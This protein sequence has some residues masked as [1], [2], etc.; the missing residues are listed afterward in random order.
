MNDFC[1]WIFLL[2]TKINFND[3]N[4]CSPQNNYLHSLIL[5]WGRAN[6]F[7]KIVER[8][9]Y[10]E[11]R[12]SVAYYSQTLTVNT[13]PFRGCIYSCAS[14]THC[15]RLCT[16]PGR[17]EHRQAQS[18]SRTASHRSFCKS[19]DPFPPAPPCPDHGAHIARPL[20]GT[21]YGSHDNALRRLPRCNPSPP[22]TCTSHYSR[23]GCVAPPFPSVWPE[24]K[25]RRL[26][27]PID[28]CCYSTSLSLTVCLVTW[29]FQRY[30]HV[31]IWLCMH[32]RHLVGFCNPTGNEP[33]C[34]FIQ[35]Q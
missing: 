19:L 31:F 1:V 13:Y 24:V 6:T 17:T 7:S 26:P 35:P 23:T 22:S 14:R 29:L 5:R 32:W 28:F 15:W 9:G 8:V 16:P 11:I 12:R 4:C 27:M 10:W 21:C 25:A 20:A 3:Y 18:F 34:L 33:I 2:N 30:R